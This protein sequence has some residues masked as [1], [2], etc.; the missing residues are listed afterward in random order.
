MVYRKQVS[1]TVNWVAESNV[2]KNDDSFFKTLCKDSV[3][4]LRKG[5]EVYCFTEEQ[6]I[7]IQR[8]APFGILVVS[9]NDLYR[10]S[11]LSC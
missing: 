6:V 4:G 10:L 3:K 1:L 2:T 8:R 9:E 7:E 5:E 11:R